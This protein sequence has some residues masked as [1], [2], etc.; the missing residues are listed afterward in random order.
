MVEG[1]TSLLLIQRAQFR[2]PTGLNFLVG[3][4]PRVPSRIPENYGRNIIGLHMTKFIFIISNL[5]AETSVTHSLLTRAVFT[6]RPTCVMAL[7]DNF[8]GAAKFSNLDLYCAIS[9]I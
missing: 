3:V 4:L 7:G 8:W 2:S 9:E 1:V 6:H 5:K